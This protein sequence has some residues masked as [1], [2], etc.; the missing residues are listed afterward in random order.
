MVGIYGQRY[1]SMGEKVGTAFQ[2]NTNSL[3]AEGTP[4]AALLNDGGVVI[5]WDRTT[6]GVWDTVAQLYSPSLIGLSNSR[7]PRLVNNTLNVLGC[8]QRYNLTSANL[9]SID[10]DSDSNGFLVFILSNV[11]NGYFELG[12]Q[13]GSGG[14]SSWRFTQQQIKDGLVGFF[15]YSGAPSY[16]ISVSDGVESSPPVLAALQY[17]PNPGNPN[18]NNPSNPTTPDEGSD[19]P[20]GTVAGNA[21]GFALLILGL[22]LAR[23]ITSCT[24]KSRLE[25]AAVRA[26]SNTKYSND[27][28]YPI[29]LAIFKKIDLTKCYGCFSEKDATLYASGVV[30]LLSKLA[31]LGVYIDLE[32]LSAAERLL[33]VQ[34]IAERVSLSVKPK[35]TCCEPLPVNE[36]SEKVDEI[37]KALSGDLSNAIFYEKLKVRPKN[38]IQI[39]MGTLSGQSGFTS[40]QNK[41]TSDPNS[42]GSLASPVSTSF[43]IN[44]SDLK[45]A[46]DEHGQH[47]ILGK[48]GFGVVYLGSWH[49]TDIAIKELSMNNLPEAVIK[50]FENEAGVMAQLR[51]N[52]LVRFYGYCLSPKYCLV[53]EYLPG[54]S[55]YQLLH[56]KKELNWDMRYQI[57][58]DIARGLAFLHAQGIMHRDIKSL[59]VLLDEHNR[60]KLTDFGLS[61]VKNESSTSTK[62]SVGTLFWMS[63][64]LFKR[65]GRYTQAS[66]IYSLGIT[67]WEIVSRKRPFEDAQDPSVVSSWVLQGERDEI[68]SDCPKKFATLIVACWDG[69]PEK[70]PTAGQVIDYLE[71]KEEDFAAFASMNSGY[72]NNF[73]SGCLVSIDETKSASSVEAKDT[74]DEVV[75]DG[76]VTTHLKVVNKV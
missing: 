68:P 11:Q 7:P 53:M 29:A 23:A 37:A 69:S 52:Y 14:A 38:L 26:H 19:F 27:T 41:S 18:P 55:L 59:N 72:V 31:D 6:E 61:R 67:L 10:D 9:G 73:A 66:D 70:R 60:A 54:G 49:Y 62:S 30:S 34:Q 15:H 13:G 56:S 75:I 45:Y 25:A 36:F 33:A 51:S 24:A 20:T 12:V 16:S 39:E 47:K 28:I 32:S 8:C 63:P 2:I 71:S 46:Q 5:S 65:G 57:A 76:D 43:V 1:N 50:D 42:R 58:K 44:Y 22:L 21:T 40:W 3:N 4:L 17:N 74:G 64:E 35:G 48:G